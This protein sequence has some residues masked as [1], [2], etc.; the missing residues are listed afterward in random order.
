MGKKRKGGER[1]IG[2]RKV[3]LQDTEAN[4]RNHGNAKFNYGG[5]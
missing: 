5:R 4:R 2:H 1:E 3:L